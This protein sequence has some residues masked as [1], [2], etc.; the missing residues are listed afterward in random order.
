MGLV[1]LSFYH[2]L[3]SNSKKLIYNAH[4]ANML[5]KERRKTGHYKAVLTSEMEKISKDKLDNNL[6]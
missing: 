2:E 4:H 5:A 3:K 1:V 6:W